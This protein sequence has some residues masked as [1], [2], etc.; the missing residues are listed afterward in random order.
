MSQIRDG[1]R[2]NNGGKKKGGGYSKSQG[3]IKWNKCC[4]CSKLGHFISDCNKEQK[5]ERSGRKGLE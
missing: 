1:E 5:I 2:Q 3:K 4:G